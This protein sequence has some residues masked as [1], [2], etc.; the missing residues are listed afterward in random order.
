MHQERKEAKA[1]PRTIAQPFPTQAS[2]PI[3]HRQVI[4]PQ[5]RTAADK[6]STRAFL[7]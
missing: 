1:T 2:A 6:A 5:E 3:P 4:N 7:R